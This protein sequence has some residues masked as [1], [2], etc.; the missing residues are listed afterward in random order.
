[1]ADASAESREL[2]ERE[3]LARSLRAA[4]ERRRRAKEPARNTV[5]MRN[6]SYGTGYLFVK[7]DYAGREVWYG[8]WRAGAA[9]VKRKIGVKRER[10][11]REGLTRPQA[12]RELRRRMEADAVVRSPTTRRTITEAGDEYIDHLEHVMERKATTIVDYRG[13]LR[14]HFERFFAERPLD[15]IDEGWVSAYLKHKRTSGLSA[16]TVQNHLNFMHGLFRFAKKRG[17]CE[18]N[19]VADIDRPKKTRTPNTR[20]NSSV[21]PSSRP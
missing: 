1:M 17:W 19:P 3:L 14:G 16:K 6:R 7:R 20:I 4:Q 18:A 2:I 15:R 21:P 10:G 13:Y 8:Q 9:K 12:E 11:S 5:A